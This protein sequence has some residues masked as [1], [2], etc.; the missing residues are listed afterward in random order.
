MPYG[1]TTHTHLVLFFFA[2]N[3]RILVR[4]MTGGD[5]ANQDGWVDL[6][7]TDE[8]LNPARSQG[9]GRGHSKSILALA[10]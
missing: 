3:D 7:W 1:D 6:L 5:P 9:V 8:P 10:S 2:F 4:R